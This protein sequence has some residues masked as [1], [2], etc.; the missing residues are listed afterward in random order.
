MKAGVSFKEI[1]PLGME[2][3]GMYEERYA[4]ETDFLAT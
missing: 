3:W 2:G 1:T 4:T